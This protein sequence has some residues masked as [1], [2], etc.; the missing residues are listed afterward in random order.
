MH[1]LFADDEANLQEMMRKEIPRMGY[2]VTVCPCGET[3]VAALEVNDFDC[4]LVDLD[5]PGRNGIEV[6]EAAKKL[7]PEVEAVIM[8]GRP[9]DES[10]R[11]AIRHHVF[12]YLN[13]P[14]KLAELAGT[15]GRVAQ[16]QAD[17]KVLA[18][19]QQRIRHQEGNSELIGSGP[20]MDAV[21]RLISKV[22]P[23]EASVL[24]R[25]ETGCGKELVARAVHDSSL[26]SGQPLVPINCGALPEHLIESELFGHCK[27]AFT[28]ADAPRRGLFEVASGGTIFLDEVGELPLAMQAKLL[29]VLETGDIRRLGDNQTTQVDV[30]VVCATHR[31]LEEMVQQGTFREDLMFRINTFEILVPPLRDRREDIRPLADHLLVRHRGDFGTAKSFTDA[32]MKRLEQHT[33]PGN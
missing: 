25:G 11:E 26:R 5:M 7:H 3:A 6:I 12:A 27:G 23:T 14:T 31:N 16:R 13:K 33:W 8:T 9:S 2:R 17:K 18:A 22:S 15:L 32:A 1:I 30:R 29:R 4:I 19:L 21:R 10:A 28:G 24:I 20:A